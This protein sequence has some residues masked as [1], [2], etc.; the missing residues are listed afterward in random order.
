MIAPNIKKVPTIPYKDQHPGTSGLRK[1]TRVFMDNPGYTEN[2]IQSV[3][4]T[5]REEPGIDLSKESLAIGGDGRYL[6]HEVMQ[7]ILSMAVAN[8]FGEILISRRGLISTP[9]MSAVIRQRKAL[10]GFILTAS[11]N[12]GGK[13]GDFGI[14]YNV[15]NGGPAPE[16]FTQRIYE[17]SLSIDHYLTAGDLEFQINDETEYQIGSTKISVIDPFTDYQTV[18]EGVFDFNKIADL[19]KS[20]FRMIFDGMHGVTG[21]YAQYF[22]E[23]LLGAAKGTVIRGEPMP[24]FGGIHPD[25]NLVYNSFL[26][27]KMMAEDAPDFGAAND[28]DG[29]RNMI[30]GHNLFIPPGDSVAVITDM[31][32]SCIP[33]FKDGVVGVAR[34]MPTSTALD[35]VAKNLGI[36]CFETP[37]GW[38]FFGNLMDAG[39]CNICG[40]E[41]FGT[42]AD[43]VREKDGLW[44]VLSWLSIISETGK[45]ARDILMGHWSKYGR[46]YYERH[47]YEEMDSDK[48][49]EMFSDMRKRL[50]KFK[51]INLSGREITRADEFCYV[52]P[53]TKNVSEHQG[54]R[55]FLADGSRIIIRLSGTGTKGATLRIYLEQFDT[56]NIDRDT[57]LMLKSLSSSATNLLEIPKYF[58]SSKPSLIT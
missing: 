40:E 30:F 37:T 36:E 33:G 50:P 38:K 34:S 41:S 28:A 6:N 4:N 25:P 13:D 5:L 53:V 7:T 31:A 55:I 15:S 56:E 29:D 39:L 1:K 23:H 19:F 44:A 43:H 24:D 11:H 12:P 54:F 9:A 32:K 22:L 58:G 2:F 47:D 14:K 16:A 27:D 8:G 35:R 48:A 20:G 42:G 3:F 21:I 18:L 46:S 45:S 26:V 51:G 57:S 10:G 17:L 52:D 49:N